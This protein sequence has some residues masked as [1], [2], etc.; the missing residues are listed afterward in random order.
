MF[1][2]QQLQQ[3]LIMCSTKEF[4][5]YLKGAEYLFLPVR[6]PK[7]PEESGTKWFLSVSTTTKAEVAVH[8]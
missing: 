6:L 5:C 7:N 4:E 3:L 8:M 1:I 2:S